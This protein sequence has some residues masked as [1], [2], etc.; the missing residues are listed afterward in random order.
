MMHIAVKLGSEAMVELLVRAG[1]DV[2]AQDV[3][4]CF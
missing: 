2:N 1:A 3:F 4:R